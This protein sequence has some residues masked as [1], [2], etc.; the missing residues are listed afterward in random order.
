MKEIK[1]TG[2]IRITCVPAG[3]APLRIRKAWVGL[4]LPCQRIC[5]FPSDGMD[6][7]VLSRKKVGRNRYGFS[8]PQGRAVR[9]L[10][11]KDPVAAAWWRKHGF[12]KAGEN[13]GF[14]E[15][16]AEI[17]SGVTRQKIIQ[18]TDEMMGDP[19]R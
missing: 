10:K 14:A 19:N 16:E 17:I 8:V 3:E 15:E 12:P 2:R 13:F 18:V 9:I 1:A 5:G 11:K 4:I 6:L 7:G